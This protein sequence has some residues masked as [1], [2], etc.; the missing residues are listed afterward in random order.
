MSEL[1]SRALAK[2]DPDVRI[3]TCLHG[4]ETAVLIDLKS[5]LA[6]EIFRDREIGNSEM[7]TVDRMDAEFAG[8]SGRLDR[9][10]NGGHSILPF[11][12]R[13][14]RSRVGFWRMLPQDG[15]TG[16]DQR[17]RALPPVDDDGSGGGSTGAGGCASGAGAA[18]TVG[19]L[20]F[21][22]FAACAVGGPG[23]PDDAASAPGSVG[24]L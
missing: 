6:V 16:Q 10:A 9:A 14:G 1:L 8:T 18:T 21:F 5:E 17:A 2:R 12:S 7:K 19:G 20:G 22:F 15:R 4:Q 3:A 23:C 11:Q 13:R 24:G